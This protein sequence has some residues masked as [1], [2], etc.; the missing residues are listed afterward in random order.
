[1]N[2][3]LIACVLATLSTGAL[4]YTHKPGDTTQDM[5]DIMA[6]EQKEREREW[7][8]KEQDALNTR[9]TQ[10]LDQLERERLHE[11][12]QKEMKSHRSYL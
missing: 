1:M 9:T 6:K 10:T 5:I 3:L 12:F 11:K 8:E 7:K 2:K 4:G